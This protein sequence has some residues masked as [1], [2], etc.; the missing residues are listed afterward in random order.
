MGLPIFL[1]GYKLGTVEQELFSPQWVESTLLDKISGQT[2]M[3]VGRG[4]ELVAVSVE[5]VSKKCVALILNPE[6]TV[7]TAIPNPFET[8]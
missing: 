7:L 4:K 3:L 8:D 5:S 2:S 1:F 6:T